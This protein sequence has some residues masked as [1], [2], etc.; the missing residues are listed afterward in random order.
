M[1]KAVI[2]LGFELSAVR[3]DEQVRGNAP[4][5][6]EWRTRAGESKIKRKNV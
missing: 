2:R 5:E 6:S 4:V 3:Q 1:A